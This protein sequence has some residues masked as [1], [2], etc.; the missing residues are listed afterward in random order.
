VVLEPAYAAEGRVRLYIKVTEIKEYTHGHYRSAL[1]IGRNAE[2]AKR[3]PKTRKLP[4]KSELRA[5]AFLPF[6][7][8]RIWEFERIPKRAKMRG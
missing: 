1:T 5:K 2:S 6:V 4:Q 8:V 3:V 7:V